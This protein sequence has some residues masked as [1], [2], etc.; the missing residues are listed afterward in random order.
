MEPIVTDTEPNGILME[1]PWK[2]HRQPVYDNLE[3]LSKFHN[4]RFLLCKQWT[5]QASVATPFFKIWKEAHHII[6]RPISRFCDI[7]HHISR[8]LMGE[9][10]STLKFKCLFVNC[11]VIL[12]IIYYDILLLQWL[13]HMEQ[14]QLILRNKWQTCSASVIVIPDTP[15]LT[16]TPTTPT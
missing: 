16:T 14:L 7:F 4:I 13:D 8:H 15:H 2:P 10:T 1:P 3:I 6:S 11:S 5:W 9:G 12:Y